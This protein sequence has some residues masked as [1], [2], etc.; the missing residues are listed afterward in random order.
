MEIHAFTVYIENGSTI[1]VLRNSYFNSFMTEVPI[2][3]KKPYN[4]FLWMGFNCLKAEA[5]TGCVL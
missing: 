1:T 5:A 3:L 2:I 4:S